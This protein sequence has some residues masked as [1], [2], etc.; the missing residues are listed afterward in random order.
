MW[1]APDETD[2]PESQELVDAGRQLRA[3]EVYY[4]ELVAPHDL[5][6]ERL[7]HEFEQLKVFVTR[8]LFQY[9]RSDESD[10][11]YGEEAAEAP[12]GGASETQSP[13]TQLVLELVLACTSRTLP[14]RVA[15][16]NKQFAAEARERFEAFVERLYCVS[17]SLASKSEERARAYRM[18]PKKK[19]LHE[20]WALSYDQREEWH[21]GNRPESGRRGVGICEGLYA[22]ELPTRDVTFGRP[23]R[24]EFVICAKS[25]TRVTPSGGFWRRDHA[26]CEPF[27]YFGAINFYKRQALPNSVVYNAVMHGVPP[28]STKWML[29][30][31]LF[32]LKRLLEEWDAFS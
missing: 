2:S 23:S 14:F 20:E 21:E 25:E 5:E 12:E 18:G 22:M 24:N 30:D 9:R 8:P 7:A 17:K 11:S 10:E 4:D 3:R 26:I 32:F 15:A 16:V 19:H 27:F 28:A 1:Y 13:D 31:Q 29:K 6:A